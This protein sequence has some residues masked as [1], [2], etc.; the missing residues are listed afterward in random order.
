[1]QSLQP[2]FDVSPKTLRRLKWVTVVAAV[3]FV[4]LVD[5]AR[6]WLYPYLRSWQG[7]LLMDATIFTGV[8][9]F[10]GVVFTLIERMQGRLERQNRELLSLHTATQDV[11]ADLS[12]DKVLQRVVDQAASLLD[13]RY[14]AISVINEQHRIESFVT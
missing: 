6:H 4:L 2:D 9:F 12:L 1:M 14:G 5:L 8:L 3:A 13:A 7:R 11:H 10:F